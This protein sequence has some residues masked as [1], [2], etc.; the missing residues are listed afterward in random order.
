MICDLETEI[1]IELGSLLV[2]S[3]GLQ[4][5]ETDITI[6]ICSS[7]SWS[8]GLY[9][10]QTKIKTDRDNSCTCTLLTTGL[11]CG[12]HLLQTKITIVL[13]HYLVGPVVPIIYRQGSLSYLSLY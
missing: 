4:D 13:A 5:L 1:A 7:L 10:L 2:W 12:L 8:C 9:L 3:C 11:V 6:V